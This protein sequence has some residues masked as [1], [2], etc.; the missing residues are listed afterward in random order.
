MMPTLNPVGENNRSSRKMISM[1]V[2]NP[3]FRAF[4]TWLQYHIRL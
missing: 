4:K 3:S 2:L 1:N